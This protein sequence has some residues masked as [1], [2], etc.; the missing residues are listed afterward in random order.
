VN[1]PYT[2]V[3][4][5]A[6]RGETLASKPPEAKARAATQV[7]PIRPR[8]TKMQGAKPP[9][10]AEA[11]ERRWREREAAAGPAGVT[12][13]GACR[14][15]GQGTW[16]ALSGGWDPNAWAEDMRARRPGRE[17]AGLV[18]AWKRGNSRGAKEPC[19]T[20]AEA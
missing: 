20:R 11:C 16:E 1:C 7:N 18:V 14:E 6:A 5:G 17:S 10:S 12:G 19:C 9:E 15:I 4:K 13:G 3:A 8:N 2:H